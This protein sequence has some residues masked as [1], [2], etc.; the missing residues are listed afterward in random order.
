MNLYE[1]DRQ[2][3][4]IIE[5]GVDPETGELTLDPEALD[6]LQMERDAKI[7]NLACY[8]KNLTADAKAIRVEEQALAERRRSAENKAERLKRYLSD[9]LAGEKFSTSRVAISWRKTSAVQVDE[10]AFLADT[11]N[12]NLGLYTMEPKISKTAIKEAISKGR[13]VSGAELVS[14]MSMS[15]K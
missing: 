4:E 11:N 12:W 6:A 5:S 14:G 13:V 1:I 2:I 9:A 8:I 10:A 15:I 3:Q 7:E